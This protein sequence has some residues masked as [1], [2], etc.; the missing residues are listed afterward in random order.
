M[1]FRPFHHGAD[2][3]DTSTKEFN[4]YFPRAGPLGTSRK[5]DCRLWPRPPHSEHRESLI[6]PPRALRY[7]ALL[8]AVLAAAWRSHHVLLPFA[9]GSPQIVQRPSRFLRSAHSYC[10]ET[11]LFPISSPAVGGQPLRPGHLGPVDRGQGG[12]VQHVEYLQRQGLPLAGAAGQVVED[13]ER[14]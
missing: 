1:T 7:L 9:R 12:V 5:C 10:R 2:R 11:F 3:P 13:V 4:C 6:A 8:V 14:L